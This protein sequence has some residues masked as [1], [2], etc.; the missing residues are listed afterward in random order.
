MAVPNTTT[1][2][3]DDVFDE[4]GYLDLVTC[5]NNSVDSYFNPL[6]KGSKDRLSN[7]RDYKVTVTLT[8]FYS[9]TGS[10]SQST[11]CGLVDTLTYYH[12]GSGSIPAVGDNV[13]SDSAGTTGLARNHYFAGIGTYHI[14]T[15]GT[16]VDSIDLCTF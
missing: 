12:D 13:Y 1:F 2:T 3:M 9:S 6:H 14:Q 4:V 16:E 15:G 7:F 11:A 8:S 5:F 10:T